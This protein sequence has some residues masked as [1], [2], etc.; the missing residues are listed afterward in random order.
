ML[1]ICV[2]CDYREECDRVVDEDGY[3]ND[4]GSTEEYSCEDYDNA[5]IENRRIAFRAEWFK[6]IESNS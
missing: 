3:C 2:Y 5:L 4:Y 6:Y 1:N